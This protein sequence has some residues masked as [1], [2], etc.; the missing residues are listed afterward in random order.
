VPI[1]LLT[2]AIGGAWLKQFVAD[3]HRDV[4]LDTV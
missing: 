2:T 1:G 3:V 4:Q